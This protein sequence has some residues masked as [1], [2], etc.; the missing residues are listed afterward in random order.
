MEEKERLRRLKEMK[1]KQAEHE[2]MKIEENR[3]K[4]KVR[5]FI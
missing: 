5:L 2:S 4:H 1:M 3:L